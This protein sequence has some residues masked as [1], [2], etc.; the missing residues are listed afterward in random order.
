MAQPQPFALPISYGLTD[1]V[2]NSGGHL[3]NMEAE[4]APRDARTPVTLRGTPGLLE[5]ADLGDF[6]VVDMIEVAGACYA[7]TRTG[8]YRLFPDGGY[9]QLGT[10]ILRNRGHMETNGLAIVMVDGLRIWSYTI[11]ADEQFWYDSS[12]AFVDYAVEL[13][14]DPNFYPANTV[15]FLNQRLIFD[16]AESN[17]F[18]NTGLLDLTVNVAAFSSAETAPDLN[19]GVIVDHQILA[20]FGS[21]TTEFWYDAGVGFSPYQ[22][23]GGGVSE[24]GAASPYA[25]AKLN[26]NI[27]A[28]AP[29]G[30]VYAYQGYQPRPIS[31]PAIEEQF[32]DRDL[33]EATAFCYTDG[34]HFYYQVTAEDFTACYDMSTNLWHVRQSEQYV[35]HRASCHAF[36][37]GKNLVGDFISGK[38]FHMSTDYMDE[39]GDP[40]IAQI[41]SGPV[42][43]GGRKVGIPQ[44]ELEI[45]VGFGG[46]T[47]APEVTPTR[48]DH[49]DPVI[50]MEVSRDD[51]KSW[52]NPRPALLGRA[53]KFNTRVRWQKNGDSRNP[54]F[55]FTISDPV[56]RSLSSRAWVAFK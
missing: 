14:S 44:V 8:I 24:H 9:F 10:V 54:R 55:R 12:A 26:N 47:P 4:V 46:A 41:I 3:I 13:T 42:P 22:R 27:F 34:G 36:A 35:R 52:G 33:S 29:E 15:S 50:T 2:K 56:R 31:T 45:D 18:Y 11:S 48:A 16:R 1:A 6:P 39:D 30:T 40:L 53:G 43:T 20:V 7:C 23:V 32:K 49:L 38:V 25:I 51:G 19:V 17:Q 21:K 28:L 37:F 5:F